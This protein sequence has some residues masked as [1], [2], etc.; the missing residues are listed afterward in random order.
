VAAV[1]FF[2]AL[3]ITTVVVV[4]LAAHLAQN[5]QIR[6]REYKLANS[7]E[8]SR[9]LFINFASPLVSLL[10]E[11]FKCAPCFYGLAICEASSSSCLCMS[12]FEI[13]LAMQQV[14]GDPF[15]SCLCFLSFSNC[16]KFCFS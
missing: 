16:C 7:N 15:L 1:V 9:V 3:A 11:I 10:A 6:E 12:S 14:D 4:I 13:D 5:K 2:M 8:F